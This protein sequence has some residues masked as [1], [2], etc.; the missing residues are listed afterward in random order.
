MPAV[1][2]VEPRRAVVPAEDV[3]V[4]FVHRGDVPEA[5]GRQR[6]A[7]P[8]R[9]PRPGQRVEVEGHEVVQPREP[10]VPG[11]SWLAELS[12]A[13]DGADATTST[14]GT[15]DSKKKAEC[16][17]DFESE[18]PPTNALRFRS[19]GPTEEIH[20]VAVHDRAIVLTTR[21]DRAFGINLD[22]RFKSKCSER[23]Q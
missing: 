16:H 11:P 14:G 4:A 15:H 13:Q 9:H 8:G 21:R 10:R 23:P 7:V 17:C 1:H 19:S 2:V 3:E 20:L 18:A 5:R 6:P 22:A 12:R